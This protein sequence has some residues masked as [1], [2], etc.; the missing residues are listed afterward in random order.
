MTRFLISICI[1]LISGCASLNP[2]GEVIKTD[3]GIIFKLNTQGKLA[4]K[5]KDVEAEI[6][7]R[8][9]SLLRTLVEGVVIQG[10][11]SD[12]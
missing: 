11:K 4:Y 12:R 5:D 1:F 2:R 9:S 8:S 10:V 3:T 6:D 7:T